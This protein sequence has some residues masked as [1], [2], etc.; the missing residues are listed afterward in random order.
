MRK[1]T[2]KRLRKALLQQL[3]TTVCL[4][5]SLWDTCLGINYIFD[6]ES[7]ALNRVVQVT[8]KYA[9][10]DLSESD[11]DEILAGLE[12]LNIAYRPGEGEKIQ[13][14]QELEKETRHTLLKAFQNAIRLQSEFW[15]TA[16]SVAEMLNCDPEGVF[17]RL[18]PF[19]F[20]ADTGMEFGEMELHAFLGEPEAKGYSFAGGPLNPETVN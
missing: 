13:G 20:A 3:R 1:V 9:G 8:P 18:L 15:I 7:D 19:S 16:N 2:D 12:K 6:D 11:L 14:I 17:C 10:K 5:T 4:Q